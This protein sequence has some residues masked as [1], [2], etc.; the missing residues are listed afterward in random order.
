MLVLDGHLGSAL[1]R[2]RSCLDQW[3][4]TMSLLLLVCSAEVPTI[5]DPRAD[6]VSASYLS[7][8]HWQ[9]R[10]LSVRLGAFGRL[11]EVSQPQ[12]ETKSDVLRASIGQYHWVAVLAPRNTRVIASWFTGWIS[13]RGLTVLT[14]SAAFAAGLQFQ[15][16]IT[17]DQPDT[18]VPQRWQGMLFY[19]LVLLYA[20]VVNI[21]GSK[22]LPH[23]NLASGQCR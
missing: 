19:W 23:T 13:V 21:W 17:L 22:I 8:V 12:D 6:T 1:I 14:A 20:A 11:R 2:R 15:A 7:L 16:L 18:Y 4:C 10:S 5:I 3:R 9:L